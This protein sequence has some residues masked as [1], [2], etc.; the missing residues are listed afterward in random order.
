MREV[1][2]K[3]MAKQNLTCNCVRCREVGAGYDAKEKLYLFKEEYEAS[4]SGKETFL[5]FE[6]KARTK[7]YGLLRLRLC[8]AEALAKAGLPL[9]VIRELHVYGQMAQIGRPQSSTNAQ[10]SG[11]GKKLMAEAE[12]IAKQ[13]KC[14]NLA[15]ISGVGV[16]GYYRKLGYKLHNTYMVK[17][18]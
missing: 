2:Q 9:A 7:L 13:N 16:R 11:L 12:K 10:H 17:K 4:S 18:L 8:H 5:S 6:N 1:V 15:V 3:E 14:K